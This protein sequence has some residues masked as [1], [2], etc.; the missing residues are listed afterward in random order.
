MTRI[1]LPGRTLLLVAG[2]PGAGKSTLLA[3]LPA[4]PGWSCSTRRPTGRP[5]A[6]CCPG[7]P[8]PGTGRW[9]TCGTG[10]RCCSPR[11][12]TQ[13]TLVV[14]L[15]ATD[16]RTRAAVARWPGSP[17][18]PRTC[19]A[20][21]RPGEA[22]RGQSPA[23]GWCPQASF[24]AHAE[25]AARDHARRCWPARPR[26]LG[27]RH[28]ARPA[29]ARAGLHLH[30]EPGTARLSGRPH[31]CRH[32]R[33]WR[34]TS[35]RGSPSSMIVELGA[36]GGRA[37]R[38]L[39]AAGAAAARPARRP[40]GAAAAHRRRPHR[41]APAL[42]RRPAPASTPTSPTRTAPRCAR[43]S[44]ASTSGSACSRC[45]TSASSAVRAVRSRDRQ[46]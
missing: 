6:G 16:E 8:T 21:R 10:S 43:C 39:R 40:A 28:R 36:A 2:M 35:R 24:A 19:V 1:D 25:Q 31:R 23:A 30:T 46:R 5:C 22:R 44:P 38:R 4:A 9:C 18:G 29:A 42:V 34:A 17:A 7:C 32:T 20:A 14:H 45:T 15:P 37:V 11:C 26:R 41:G 13:P 27:H 3:G 33:P 12:P